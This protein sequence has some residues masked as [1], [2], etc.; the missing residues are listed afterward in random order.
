MRKFSILCLVIAS[1]CG[2]PRLQAQ[3]FVYRRSYQ[4]SALHAPFRSYFKDVVLGDVNNDGYL[5]IYVLQKQT[6]GD[7]VVDPTIDILYLNNRRKLD[8]SQGTPFN[9]R[10]TNAT[11]TNPAAILTAKGYDGE[12]RDMDG[13]GN[14]DIIRIDRGDAN[15]APTSRPGTVH[16]MWGNGSGQFTSQLINSPDP[17]VGAI[18]CSSGNVSA[19][20]N[21]DNV[22]VADLD[23]DGDLD[24]LVS[25]YNSCGCNLLV[26]NNGSRSFSIVRSNPSG[27]CELPADLTHTVAIGDYNDD[28]HPD[29]LLG[30]YD[31][32]VDVY[33]GTA[34]PFVFSNSPMTLNTLLGNHN[35]VTVSQFEDVNQ[36]GL[37]D[38]VVGANERIGFFL[39][40]GN[41]ANPYSGGYVYEDIA[42][43]EYL[44]DTRVSDVDND[45]NMDILTIDHG[46]R[47]GAGFDGHELVG[48][49]VVG[50]SLINTTSAFF[51]V[52]FQGIVTLSLG[53]LDN[54]GDLD[55][56]TGGV[57][58]FPGTDSTRS[59]IH[60]YENVSGPTN[61]VQGVADIV[62]HK[63][64]V[65]VQ[66]ATNRVD[67]NDYDIQSGAEVSFL[68]GN[69]IIL[70]DGFW[71]RE[72]VNFRAFLGTS[73][74]DPPNTQGR[75]T[76]VEM[77]ETALVV[78]ETLEPAGQ[79]IMAY[80]NP[81]RSMT[82]LRYEMQ[83]PGLVTL[84][85]YNAQGQ[86]VAVPVEQKQE[87][88]GK[89]ELELDMASMPDGLYYYRLQAGKQRLSGALRKQA[90]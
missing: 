12:L 28:G 11:F 54:D 8:G 62:V 26:R 44:Y 22:E 40:N 9:F 2:V 60:I 59:A 80:P 3:D 33:A 14:L 71:A 37:L 82:T 69:D 61:I 45:L 16:V 73:F 74:F 56:V 46:A 67:V 15:I 10:T 52:D 48:H 66:K 70:R 31:G 77:E 75:G 25:Q 87:T 81:F 42:T 57:G 72:G 23:G 5:D 65:V 53:D 18:G 85:L 55:M 1:V 7:T 39:H 24:F 35:P 86:A 21:Y 30:K 50:N 20:V 36:D 64:R 78:D 76:G 6:N 79:P 29:V 13:D 27:I 43:A 68:A 51:G 63:S 19:D 90:E 89:H 4:E 58:H 47:N 17:N 32:T 49:T 38:V 88:A 34:S 41:H 84:V 83:E